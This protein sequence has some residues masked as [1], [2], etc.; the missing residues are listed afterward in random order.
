[1]KVYDASNERRQQNL[2]DPSYNPGPKDRAV[3]TTGSMILDLEP[4]YTLDK[5]SAIKPVN[6]NLIKHNATRVIV[7]AYYRSGSSA[8]GRILKYH[9]SSFYLYEPFKLDF[10]EYKFHKNMSRTEDL[11]VNPETGHYR[12]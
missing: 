11:F 9:P 6:P 3:T 1:M 7:D 4:P 8:L 12:Y 10:M 2:V 5:L